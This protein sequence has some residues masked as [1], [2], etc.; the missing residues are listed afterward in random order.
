MEVVP[1]STA[2]GAEVF[3]ADLSK[4]HDEAF[5][6]ELYRCFLQFGVLAIRDQDLSPAAHVQVARQ[7]GAPQRDGLETGVDGEMHVTAIVKEPGETENFGHEW[8]QDMSYLQTPPKASLLYGVEVPPVGG[9]TWFASLAMA[10]ACLS[11]KMREMLQPLQVVHENWPNDLS[12]FQGMAVRGGEGQRTHVRRH[13]THDVIGSHPETSRKQLMVSPYYAR[14]VVGMSWDESSALLGYLNDWAVSPE[15]TCRIR[16]TPGT[17]TIW[18]NRAVIHDV[19]S[20]DFGAR[21]G[22]KGFRR[23]MHRVTVH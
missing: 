4:P 19:P 21:L 18:D 15:F 14:E 9:D 16:W 6:A 22:G 2:I 20:D 5:W 8:H 7:F 10:Y 12:R 23:R 17:L 3:G 13:T 11:E 1:I